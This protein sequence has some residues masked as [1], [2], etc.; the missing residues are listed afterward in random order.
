MPLAGAGAGI[1]SHVY[2][3]TSGEGGWAAWTVADGELLYAYG[4]W[5]E[6]ERRLLIFARRSCWRRLGA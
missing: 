2:A 3:D 6:D 5:T 4:V 1:A